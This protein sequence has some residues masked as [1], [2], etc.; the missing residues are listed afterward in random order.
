VI[1]YIYRHSLLNTRHIGHSSGARDG[2]EDFGWAIPRRRDKSL[3][4]SPGFLR[5]CRQISTEASAVRYS[6]NTFAFK[7]TMNKYGEES[8]MF[9]DTTSHI[10]DS[11]LYH[12]E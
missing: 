2:W 8:A 4:L 1:F 6:E 5:A 11:K 3:Y 9:D 10:S 7:I 12:G